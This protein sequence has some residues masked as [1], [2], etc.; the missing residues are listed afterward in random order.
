MLV[1]GG[2][3]LLDPGDLLLT[4]TKPPCRIARFV[5]IPNQ[6]SRWLSQEARVGVSCIWKRDR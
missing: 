6:R 5:M 4:L 2:C 3:G 1:G